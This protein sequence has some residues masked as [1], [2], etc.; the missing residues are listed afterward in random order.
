MRT[1]KLSAAQ[2]RAAK[3]K[4]RAYRLG[5]GNGLYLVVQPSG[6]KSWI[7]RLV[8]H[9]IR[10]D[11]GLGSFDYL[12]LKEA[13]ETAAE[14]RRLARSGKDPRTAKIPTVSEVFQRWIKANARNYRSGT[15]T[16][17][18]ISNRFE[19]YVIPR[20][21]H[22]PVDKVG[23]LLVREVVT[24]I[25][26]GR[27]YTT[28]VK[29]GQNLGQILE[30]AVSMEWRVDPSPTSEV[31]KQFKRI[32]PV[33]HAD[34]VAFDQ[35][36]DAIKA[37][38]TNATQSTSDAFVFQVLTN[39]RTIEMRK[40]EWHQ[41]DLGKRVWT[42]PASIMKTNEQH[43][44]PLSTQAIAILKRRL[45]ARKGR[46]VFGKGNSILGEGTIYTA[47]RRAGINANPHGFRTS[48]NDWC[49]EN[50]INAGV[51]EA[52][53]SHAIPSAVQQAYNQTDLLDLRRPVMGAW[54]DYVMQSDLS[55]FFDL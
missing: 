52:C 17:T 47:V 53:M 49:R 25:F 4:D 30:F 31:L 37:V 48:F 34:A 46:Y 45:A 51:R 44:V 14:N 40:C 15:R 9:G 1:N 50:K 23:A 5:D 2:C 3:P 6:S 7:Q 39:A 38:Q 8:I 18:A 16:L 43:V 41:I 11:L 20:I 33:E 35:V 42:R 13:R 21:G 12:G 54:A 27:K 29:V 10:R 24:P 26:N 55:E 19:E 32:D 28:A 22:V 36:R